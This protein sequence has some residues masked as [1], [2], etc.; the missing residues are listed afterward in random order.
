[1]ET[2]TTVNM[3]IVALATR[4]AGRFTLSED[5]V[6][7]ELKACVEDEKLRTPPAHVDAPQVPQAP[8]RSR[9]RRGV[10]ARL[11]EDSASSR[12]DAE[13]AEA[14]N[15]SIFVANVNLSRARLGLPPLR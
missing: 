3:N 10:R 15:E 7:N 5:E 6:L 2:N 8:R 1:M 12:E 11:F 4:L 14:I 13:L 9:R